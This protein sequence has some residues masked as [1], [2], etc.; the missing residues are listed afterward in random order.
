MTE[1]ALQL[2]EENKRTKAKFL[3]LGNCG[4]VNELPK[5]LF[6]CVWLEEL[7]FAG[8]F[9][10]PRLSV[11]SAPKNPG[12]SND[13]KDLVISGF[14]KFTHMKLLDLRGNRISDISFLQQLTHL[15]SLYLHDNRITDISFL[16][17]LTNLQ[18]L[19]LS[20]NYISDFS[21]LQQLTKL[22]LLY[23]SN[24]PVSDVGFLQ[25]LTN[26]KSLD[27]S[28]NLLSDFSFLQQLTNLQS[29][30]LSHN[31]IDDLSFLQQLTKLQLLYL[32]NNSISDI[33]FLQ[34]LT[35]LQ[36]L[37]LRD[38]HISEISFLQ[39]HTNLQSLDLSSND[40]A[41][42]P[43][44]TLNSFPILKYLSLYNNPIKNIPA[45]IYRLNNC[46]TELGNFLQDRA[47]ESIQVF[48]SKLILVGNGRTGKTSILNRLAHNTFNP[49]EPS[50]HAI[51]MEMWLLPELAGDQELERIQLNVW[52][53]GGQDIYHA[54]H[55]YFLQTQALFILV[56]DAETEPM[57]KQPEADDDSNQTEKVYYKN[58]P[59]QYWLSYIKTKSK[60]S[61][62]IVVQTKRDVHG[63]KE[64]PLTPEEKKYFNVQAMLSVDCKENKWSLNGFKLL[65][66][67]I[68][69]I[70][71][72]QVQSN[73][74]E[75]PAQ[76]YRI[77]NHISGLEKAKIKR[78]DVS[79]FI[80]MCYEEGLGNSSAD[81]LLRYLHNSGV[82]Y[83]QQGLFNNQ[84]VVDQQWVINAV[85]T[86]F[87]RKGLFVDL[88]HDGRFTG[89]N[90]QRAWSTFTIEEQ[91]LFVSFMQ[92]CEI[93]FE[94][95]RYNPGADETLF[96]ER[97]F[98]APQLLP[99]E[100]PGAIKYVFTDN[101]GIFVK[102]KHQF[103]H[104]A[105]IQ[106][107]IVRVGFLAEVYNMWNMGV[108]LQLNG[109]AALIEAFPK[110]NEILV[111]I[112]SSQ[113]LTLLDKIRNEL[114][115][116][117]HDETGIQE[118]GSL[119]GI[120]FVLLDHLHHHP[121]GN[122]Q[123]QSENGH[124]VPVAEYRLFLNR[125]ERIRF[126]K[127]RDKPVIYFSYA[128]RD[129]TNEDRE[130]FVD[131]LYNS[132]KQ[133]GEYTVVRDKEDVL[134]K[135]SLSGFMKEI[136][137][138]DLVVVAISD[139]YLKSE[140][141]MYELHELYLNSKSQL[142][143]LEKKIFPVMIERLDLHKPSVLVL[144]MDHWLE[145]EKE[146]EDLV[147]KRASRIS[148]AQQERYNKIKKIASELGSFL[149]FLADMNTKTPELLSRN[150]FEEIK[151][152]IKQ[153]AKQLSEPGFQG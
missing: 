150:D 92:Q 130:K 82:F 124:W 77:R 75:I 144:Y 90:L 96:T 101:E 95:K 1:L 40:I 63:E 136:G 13:F 46:I 50:T 66:G 57:L 8:N 85:Y 121:P 125:D 18:S 7:S 49:D 27:L 48:E 42:F 79:R 80:E 61:P 41:F 134:Y 141:C 98:I 93:C 30:E 17:H 114:K 147:T 87:D 94:E 28:S 44:S 105:V 73:C 110:R 131:A 133:E 35:N 137:R 65:Q 59:L 111:R 102:Y 103:L 116:I 36:S 74:T 37:N 33:S 126:D 6:D 62:I 113:S 109:Q 34:R 4:L 123:I 29:L 149:D 60:G 23:L 148:P 78:I 115:E 15:E 132:L 119:D 38:N 31:S 104:A 70:V 118:S 120:N 135:Q 11:S 97:K 22:Q 84:I 53:F 108:L 139:K 58:H 26:L 25:R 43:F 112:K 146:W 106:R 140:Y 86:L 68:E 88:Q 45:Q 47:Y 151:T 39:Q 72:Q 54:T 14:E 145:Q 3:D 117:N 55:R 64:P 19:G 52:D 12:Q 69:A 129:S 20:H 81:T 91:E 2:I 56:W 138:S 122:E 21:S 51:K 143:G 83:Y 89:K 153:R 76:W 128:W 107:F 67:K 16:Q 71:A 5:E 9:Y 24:N 152:A 32:S 142:A 100:K 10:A 127:E 99:E